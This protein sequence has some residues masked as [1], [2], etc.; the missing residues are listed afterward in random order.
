MTKTVHIHIGPHSADAALVA[1][2]LQ[3]NAQRL[4]DDFGL[5]LLDE[6]TAQQAADALNADQVEVAATALDELS[7]AVT[8]T[9]GDCLLSMPDF[10][11]EILGSNGKR[12]PYPRVTKNLGVI[13]RAFTG[14]D[15]RFY[16]LLPDPAVYLDFTYAQHLRHR[17]RFSTQQ[18]FI[19]HH[20]TDELWGICMSKPREKFADSLI[21]IPLERRTLPTLMQ[22][23]TGKEVA[24]KLREATMPDVAMRTLF[25]MING[26][27]ASPFA[28]QEAKAFL[29]ASPQTVTSSTPDQPWP[30]AAQSP[31]WLAPALRPLWSRVE[32][33]VAT[34]DQPNLLPALDA[35]LSHL[36]TQIVEAPDEF[37]SGGRGP[38][39]NQLR[40]LA[41][42]FRGLPQTC[43]MLGLTVSYLRRD[44]AH[45]AHAAAIFQRLWVEEHALLLGTLPTRWLISAFQT[46]MDHGTTEAQR[47]TGAAAYFMANTLKLYEAERAIEGLA[48][49]ATY[50]GTKPQTRQGF[51]GLDRFDVGGSD[52]MLN[53]NAL[54][55]DLASRDDV[56]GRVV[57]EFILRLKRAKT[58]FSRMDQNRVTHSATQKQFANCWS[59]FVPPKS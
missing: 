19:D 23:I 7:A 25:E 27:S 35:D 17:T 58:A 12:R 9:E 32:K 33:R 47:T 41:Y 8:T 59:F 26:G 39:D 36:R 48:P 49:D 50:P 54:L 51:R 1:S 42:R 37:P 22:A 55:L 28:K 21:T 5:T 52:M 16:A 2:N 56:S 15:V 57:Q 34:Q 20:Q 31:D 4:S 45:T 29:E 6:N 53:T 38:M 43:L 14:C 24:Y 13:L 18:A 46:F 44:T 11:G 40:I 30:P 10:C 3:D